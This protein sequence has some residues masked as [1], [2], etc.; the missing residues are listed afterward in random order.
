MQ[1]FK[2]TNIHTNK[3]IDLNYNELQDFMRINRKNFFYN[4]TIQRVNKK[5]ILDNI[6]A[7]F[8]VAIGSIGLLLLGS[9]MDTYL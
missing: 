4:Y 2:I 9:M 6:I 3:V 7:F 5:S 8:I 1:H